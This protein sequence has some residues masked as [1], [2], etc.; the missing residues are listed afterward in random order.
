[1]RFQS[2]IRRSTLAL[3]TFACVGAPLVSTMTFAQT[4]ASPSAPVIGQSNSG[5]FPRG[6]GGGGMRRKLE[7]LNLTESQRSQ[8]QDIFRRYKHDHKNPAFRQ[9]INAVL[10]PEQRDQ[11]KGRRRGGFRRGRGRRLPPATTNTPSAT[12][13]P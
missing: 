1:M 5:Q 12:P 3:A 10:T 9:E 8:I 13:K 7:R 4:P 11:L 6:G 2:L